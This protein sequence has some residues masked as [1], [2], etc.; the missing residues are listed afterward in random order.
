MAD[1]TAA[2]SEGAMGR[3]TSLVR[4]SS[5]R[6]RF[7][8]G[9]KALLFAAAAVSVAVTLAMVV[10]LALVAVSIVVTGPLAEAVGAQIGVG[11]EAVGVRLGENDGRPP[12]PDPSPP[13]APASSTT[14]NAEAAPT[15]RAATLARMATTMVR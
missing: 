10:L 14:R 9:V 6:S 5:R 11:S 1:H 2:A 12:G 3:R 4:R 8:A 13:H 7:E 15:P